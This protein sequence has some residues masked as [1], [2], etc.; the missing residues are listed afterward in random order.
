MH[1]DLFLQP[2][3]VIARKPADDVVD[4]VFRAALALRLLH[5]ERID[6]CK[7]HAENSMLGHRHRLYFAARTMRRTSVTVAS[8][9]VLSQSRN[10]CTWG[11]SNASRRNRA[12][13]A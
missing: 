8:A 3:L 7:F 9:W 12:W 5:I 13:K 11:R 2:F 10:R 1:A 4:L 6:F